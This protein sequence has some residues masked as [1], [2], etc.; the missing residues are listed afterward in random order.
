MEP[1]KIVYTFS[2]GKAWQ[3]KKEFPLIINPES[4]EI[5]RPAME[6]LPDWA[7]L[8]FC[9][10]PNCTLTQGE[11]PFCPVAVNLVSTVHGLSAL[12][13]YD[14]VMVE[15]QT[16]ERTSS[17]KTTVQEGVRSLVGLIMAVSGCPHTI[18]F[19]PM[20]RFHLPLASEAE[21]IYRAASM[22]LLAQFFLKKEG[23]PTDMDLEGLKKIYHNIQLVNY[24]MAARIREASKTDSILNAIVELDIYAQTLSIVIEDSLDEI[25][26]IFAPF[27][28]D[29]EGG[30]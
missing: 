15:V 9:Q 23:H 10:C 11:S 5:D 18:Y 28:D 25:R 14:D 13:S 1:I 12:L 22:Y 19:K 8:D 7:R 3:Q 29:N 21:T 6:S 20:A 17:G 30:K 4:L 2:F 26:H 16:K 24:T 27:L